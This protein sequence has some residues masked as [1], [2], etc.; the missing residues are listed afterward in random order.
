MEN[1]EGFSSPN[2]VDKSQSSG[3]K[4]PPTNINQE[5][6]EQVGPDIRLDQDGEQGGPWLDVNR[7]NYITLRPKR[8]VNSKILAQSQNIPDLN[9]DADNSLTSDPFN[10]EEIS[11]WRNRGLD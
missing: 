4:L 6:R 9:Q 5:E 3:N 2:A 8:G 10:I 1:F 11:G 7:P